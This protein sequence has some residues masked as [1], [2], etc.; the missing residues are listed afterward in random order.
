MI[1][2]LSS[3]WMESSL[4]Q[5]G[6]D[7]VK[8]RDTGRFPVESRRVVCSA[9][10]RSPPIACT[11]SYMS[12][13]HPA[14]SA[15]WFSLG[16]LIEPM[17]SDCQRILPRGCHFTIGINLCQFLQNKKATHVFGMIA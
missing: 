11:L 16:N 15:F 12:R 17:V 13:M 9:D 2:Q 14:R 5:I 1:R 10:F 8:H 4:V 3:L 7:T 6:S